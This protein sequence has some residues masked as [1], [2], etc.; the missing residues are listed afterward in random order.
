MAKNTPND[1]TYFLALEVAHE[2]YLGALRSWENL[3][4]A[5]DEGV[6]WIKDLRWDQ[7]EAAEVK[8]IPYK[9]LY[10]ARENKLFPLHSLLPERN[11]PSLL[12]TPIERALPLSLPALNH[13]YFGINQQVDVQLVP[14]N[15]EEPACALVVDIEDL[16]TYIYQ[17]PEVRLQHLQWVLINQ[18]QALVMGTPVLPISG[19]AYWEKNDFLLPAGYNFEFHILHPAI[20]NLVNATGENRVIWQENGSYFLVRKNDFRPLSKS[21]LLQTLTH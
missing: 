2:H 8:T 18:Q 15:Q 11:V 5:Q 20:D 17:A 6:I 7:V 10:Y 3:K 21:S 16:H 19:Q 13:N 4:M 12:F 9:T 14:A 1:L